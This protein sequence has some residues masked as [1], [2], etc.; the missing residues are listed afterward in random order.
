MRRTLFVSVVLVTIAVVGQPA[1]AASDRSAT[2]GNKL[3]CFDGASEG[4]GNGVCVLGA[5]GS[6]T[7]TNP[8][9]GDYAG[10]YVANTNLDGKSIADINQLSFTYS[11]ATSGGSPRI[12]FPID[13]DG[14]GLWDDF[15]SA[16]AVTCTDGTAT[17]GTVDVINDP[18]CLVSLNAGPSYASWAAFV[19]AY[20]DATV[21][22]DALPFVIADQPGTVNVS[23]VRIGRGPAHTFH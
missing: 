19:A 15:V 10:V 17:A 9:A 1:G 12:T 2:A 21:A 14:D 16:D 13:L 23:D 3:L 8:A 6:A 18:T 5:G 11:G 20:P 4:A 22:T 7:L